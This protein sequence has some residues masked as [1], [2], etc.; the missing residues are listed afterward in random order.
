MTPISIN[1]IVGF[2]LLYRTLVLQPTIPEFKYFF[3][4]FTQSG[5][6]TL[7]RRQ[8]VPTLKHNKKS[9]KNWQD[10]FLWV[11]NDLVELA[12]ALEKI[13]IKGQNW[14]DYFSA[15][16]GMSVAWRARGEMLEL[17]VEKEVVEE[18]ISLEKPLQG[19]FD[20]DLHL[21]YDDLVETL[22]PPIS[23]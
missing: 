18:V 14:L 6:R 13:N 20:G 23:G 21:R 5:T 9:K 3:N 22:P 4:A 12:D 1:K 10:K 19:L 11:N 7:S 15:T 17:F 8:G 16:S 2:E